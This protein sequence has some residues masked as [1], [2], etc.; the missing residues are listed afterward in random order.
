MSLC[1]AVGEN[2]SSG[3]KATFTCSNSN[4]VPTP[5]G[6]ISQSGAYRLAENKSHRP[7]ALEFMRSAFGEPQPSA[8]D[9]VGHDSDTRTSPGAHCAMTR[10]AACTAMP[11]ISRP[12]ISISP[13]C[14]PA[15]RGRPICLAA[16]PND[17][18][19][20][21]RASGPVERRENAVAGGFD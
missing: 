10:A 16:A 15:R 20:S 8:S 12:L 18:R 19:A 5:G 1:G 4:R 3:G 13:V 9:E 21:D 14:R 7:G 6:D 11:P 2:V 17:K